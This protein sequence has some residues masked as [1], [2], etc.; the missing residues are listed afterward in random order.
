MRIVTYK[1]D[2]CGKEDTDNKIRLERVGVHVGYY[3]LQYSYGQGGNRVEDEY[4]KDWCEEC[5]IRSGFVSKPKE[6]TIDVS[7]PSL[8]EIIREMIYGIAQE[9]SNS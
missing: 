7:P 5:C 2:R 8:D 6:S 3:Q 1:C 4:N 9:A